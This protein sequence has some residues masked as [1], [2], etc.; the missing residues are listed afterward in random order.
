LKGS[1]EDR[2]PKPSDNEETSNGM[3]D[4]LVKETF[5]PVQRKR[6]EFNHF[7]ELVKER[8]EER[9]ADDGDVP[10]FVVRGSTIQLEHVALYLEF[11]QRYDR[12]SDFVK[13]RTS[14]VS[15]R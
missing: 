13:P 5:D 14:S 3:S 10:K 2:H 8:V 1:G 9:N 12:P 6:D 11:D 7:L 15:M 4:N